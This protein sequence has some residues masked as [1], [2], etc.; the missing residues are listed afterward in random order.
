VGIDIIDYSGIDLVSDAVAA[1]RCFPDAAVDEVFSEHF[2]EHL[3][4]PRDIL[5][6][7]ARVLRQGGIFRAVIPHFSNPWFYSD[8]TH[9]SFFGLYSFGYWVESTYFRRKV[10]HYDDALP[11]ELVSAT[12]VF[13]SAP[14][15]L[16]R[17]A[18]KKALSCWVNLNRW[19]QEFYEE[20]LS[21]VLPCYEI[22]FVLRRR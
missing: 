10:P 18:V 19:T 14:P 8:P 4:N 13:K 6:E 16:V 17:H 9:R 2:M 5:I 22:D 20:S 21:S 1:L 3:D 11:F 7:A 12:H 15:F